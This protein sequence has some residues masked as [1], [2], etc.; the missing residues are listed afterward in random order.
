MLILE[1]QRCSHIC[2][3]YLKSKDQSFAL[4]GYFRCKF[5]KDNFSYELSKSKYKD[6]NISKSFMK[7][8]VQQRVK[9]IWLKQCVTFL[10]L[11]TVISLNLKLYF[12]IFWTLLE[13]FGLVLFSLLR[14]LHNKKNHWGGF[15]S[16][17]QRMII[18]ML[19]TH[20][21]RFIKF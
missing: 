16:N 11:A 6:I 1:L 17:F 12:R 21:Q 3:I 9:C 19:S 10:I 5:L 15:H 18:F 13:C 4:T 2:T 7:K 20:S 14:A 8:L